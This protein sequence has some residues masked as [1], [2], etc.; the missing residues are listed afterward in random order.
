MQADRVRIVKNAGWLFARLGVATLADLLVVR[1]LVGGFGVARFGV[2]AAILSVVSFVFFLRWAVELA[3]RRVL[4]VARGHGASADVPRI[5]SAGCVFSALVCAV[6]LLGA[7]TG[8]LYFADTRLVLDAD[9][10]SLLVPVFQL[11]VAA[12]AVETLRMPFEALIIA[13]ERMAFFAKVSVASAL[14]GL[15]S[16]G[17]ALF[18]KDGRVEVFMACCLGQAIVLLILYWGFCR[19]R[20]P[21]LA[22]FVMFRREDLA[23]IVRF[24]LKSLPSD[25]ANV[26][27]NDGVG[28][29]LNALAG[30]RYNA[31]YRMSSR[32]GTS[33]YGIVGSFQQAYFPALVKAWSVGDRDA[34]RS[35]LLFTV[36]VSATM[37]GVFVLP[38]LVATGPILSFWIGRE[39]PPEAVAFVRCVAAHYFFSALT[40]PFHTLVLAT[41]RIGVYQLI[42]ASFMVA[43]FALAWVSLACGLPAWT[44]VGAVALTNALS[45]VYRVFCVRKLV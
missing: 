41:G 32:V 35:L 33:V 31:T 1:L 9:G 12:L 6:L 7:E 44:S 3:I 4:S 16:A 26:L 27:K 45:F 29:V 2:Y 17:A 24:F 39:L 13:A 43:G 11:G 30:S 36:R 5:F 15:L 38:L 18:V 8:G 28:L 19:R 40:A 25:L 21:D 37:S 34:I 14:M 10:R 22:R 20:L 42:V 23:G